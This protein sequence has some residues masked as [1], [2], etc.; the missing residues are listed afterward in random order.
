MVESTNGGWSMKKM[1]I[2]MGIGSGMI[3]YFANR[4]DTIVGCVCFTL[5]IVLL[6]SSIVKYAN[7]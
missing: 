3:G 7:G 4:L 6:V 2:T 5:G 1:M